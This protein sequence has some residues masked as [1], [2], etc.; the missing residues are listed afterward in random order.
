MKWSFLAG[1]PAPVKYILC[2]CEEGDPG[3]FNDKTIL[4]ADPFTLNRGLRHRRLR[5]GG[6]ERRP[7]SSGTG[8]DA[9][10][11]RTRAAIS[12]CYENGLLGGGVLG[13]EIRV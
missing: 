11:D 4:E 12:V 5:D 3:A 9:P 6:V 10:I 2:N 7:S 1:N 8:T 13:T